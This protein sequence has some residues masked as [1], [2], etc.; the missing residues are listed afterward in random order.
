VTGAALKQRSV[1]AHRYL[2]AIVA[3][4]ALAVIADALCQL[5]GSLT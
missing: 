4:S 1:S 5:I 3:G 2:C